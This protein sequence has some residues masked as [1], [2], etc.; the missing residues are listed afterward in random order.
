M[1]RASRKLRAR[2]AGGLVVSLLAGAFGASSARAAD[3]EDIYAAVMGGALIERQKNVQVGALGG[4]LFWDGLGF[5]LGFDQAFAR[6]GSQGQ[7]AS[8]QYYGEGRWFLEPFE[9]FSGGGARQLQDRVGYWRFRPVFLTG[10]DYLVALT[11][12]LALRLEL[13][14]QYLFGS[15]TIL[16]GWSA[17]TGVGVR[18]LY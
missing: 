10:A 13:R 15:P 14:A 9:V 12:S 11:A 6:G 5:G 4:Y 2:A 8:A 7:G 17:F 1:A 18:L 16:A 3:R